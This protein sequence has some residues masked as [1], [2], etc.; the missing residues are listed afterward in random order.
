[1]SRFGYLTKLLPISSN[2]RTE[3]EVG[4][5]NTSSVLHTHPV[6]RGK[7]PCR[8]WSRVGES[9]VGNRT[10]TSTKS[11]PVYRLN[12]TS[13]IFSPENRLL[14][15]VFKVST[16][17]KVCTK[18]YNRTL[19]TTAKRWYFFLSNCSLPYIYSPV[20]TF[21]VIFSTTELV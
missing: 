18:L 9:H 1:M 14:I 19:T 13:L 11:L 5:S 20:S 16:T 2:R 3:G 12:Q 21:F 8:G 10:M 17:C 7:D 4:E 6:W 15:L